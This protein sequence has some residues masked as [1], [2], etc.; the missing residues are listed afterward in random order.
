MRLFTL[1]F[2]LLSILGS[3]QTEIPGFS[4]IA[5]KNDTTINKPYLDSKKQNW[6][7]DFIFN[8][9]V[10]K[11]DITTGNIRLIEDYPDQGNYH[12]TPENGTL[13]EKK[14]LLKIV[15]ISTIRIE[16]N[17]EEKYNKVIFKYLD[18]KFGDDWRKNAPSN[19]I[20]I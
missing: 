6:P 2:P 3:A 13:F 14:F 8:D 4:K 9:S 12:Y 16:G 20:G 19:I 10:A 18:K 5:L 7:S 1:I 11:T 15:S 17:N